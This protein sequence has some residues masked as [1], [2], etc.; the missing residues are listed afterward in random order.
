MK[1]SPFLAA[2]ALL[3]SAAPALAQRAVRPKDAPAQ[4]VVPQEAATPDVEPLVPT[5][6]AKR[7]AT[8]VEAA[9]PSGPPPAFKDDLTADDL[10]TLHASGSVVNCANGC[11]AVYSKRRESTAY[12]L[13]IRPAQPRPGQL[14]EAIVELSE[15]LENPDPEY[16]DRKPVTGEGLVAHVEGVGRFVL[17]PMDRDAGGYGFHFTA[18]GK[19]S[20]QIEIARLNGRPG[21]SVDFNVPLGTAPGKDADLR[22]WHPPA[23]KSYAAVAVEKSPSED[24]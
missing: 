17:H 15:I 21:L 22:E 14:V 7:K 18:P 19:G 6:G 24:E 20:R 9:K 10:K 2:L 11:E 5:P 23:A 4:V 13:R 8:P 1:C 16:G 12:S 3:F